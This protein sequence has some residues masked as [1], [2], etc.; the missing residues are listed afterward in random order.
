MATLTLPFPIPCRLDLRYENLYFIFIFLLV[1][2][3]TRPTEE[4]ASEYQNANG[5]SE[6]RQRDMTLLGPAAP[7]I[8]DMAPDM[9]GEVAP[10]NGKPMMSLYA[11]II[12]GEKSELKKHISGTCFLGFY[13]MFLYA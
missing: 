4:E 12:K 11:A 2:N 3:S 5:I 13:N 9:N 7:N 8:G 1:N 10:N 6:L